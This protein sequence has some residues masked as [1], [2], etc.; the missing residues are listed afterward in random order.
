MNFHNQLFRILTYI[1]VSAGYLCGSLLYGTGVATAALSI[2]NNSKLE[3]NNTGFSDTKSLNETLKGLL[4]IGDLV[5]GKL[6]VE[7]ISQKINSENLPDST[8]A[9]SYY[10]LGIYQLLTRSY[11]EA[12]HYLTLCIS[13]KEKNKK[14]DNLYARALYN[15]SVAFANLGEL[16]E[17]EYYASKSLKVGKTIYGESSPVLLN[18]YLSLISAY[19]DLKEYEKAITNSNIALTIANQNS[20]AISPTVLA[21]LYFNLGVCSYR[22]ADYSKAKIYFDKTESI[23]KNS[24]LDHDESY[25]N[26]LNGFAINYNSLGLTSESAEYYDKGVRLAILKN[27]PL[28]LNLIN[29]YSIFLGNRGHVEKGEKLLRDALTRAKATY[30]QNPHNYFEV[31]NNYSNY[32]LEYM[33][34]TKRSIENYILCLSYLKNN[35]QD[36]LLKTSVCIG[37]SRALEKAGKSE[38]ALEVIHSLLFPERGDAT[39]SGNFANPAFETLKP[40]NTSLKILNLKYNILWDIYRKKADERIL[41]AASNTSELIV[42]LLDKA[43]INISEEDSRLILGDKYRDSYL[44]AIRD[45]NLLYNISH[46]RQYLE[47]AFEYSE[48]SKVAGLLTS[49]RELKAAQFHIPSEIG[50]I[51]RDLQREISLINAHISEES[52]SQKPNMTLISNWKENLLNYSRKRDSLILVIEKK[53]PEYYAIKYNTQMAGL[54]DIPSIVGH[55][56]NYI[57]YVLSDTVLYTFIV[58]RRYQQILAIPVDSSFFN[59]IR[60]FRLLLSMPSPSDDAY[61]KFNE[62]QTIGYTLYKKLIEPIKPYLISDRILISP[63]N[64]LSYLPFETIPSSTLAGGGIRYKDI[65]YLMDSYDISYT[66]SATFAAESVKKEYGRNNKLIAFAPDYPEPI[67]IQSTLMSRQ[68]GMGVLNDLPFA[69]Q[70]AKYV[71]DLTGG[72]LFENS[73]AKESVYKR[74]SG[75]YDIIHLAMH[76]LLNDKDPMHS[77]L[78]FSRGNDSP[79]D[80]FLKTYEVYGIPL[81]AK[82]VFL[83]SCNTGSGLLYSGEGILSLARGFIYSGSQSVVMSMWEIEDKSGTEIVEKFYDN[84]RKGYSKSVSLKRARMTFLKNAD[85]LRSHPYF[86]ATLVVYGNNTPLY[87][88][89]KLIIIPSAILI[90]LGLLAGVYYRKRKYS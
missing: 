20:K 15:L 29:S 76:T 2:N 11:K 3:F 80:G 88:P 9:E 59:C 39:F 63:D 71:S 82:M 33:S 17:F 78:I 4:T 38:K 49:T 77:T 50:D 22:L 54:K 5:N 90:I 84:L 79:Q 25:I 1:I 65:S 85:Q 46:N 43:R 62:F 58:N 51:E 74:E 37:Y 64:I 14:I 26:V 12:I 45:F 66:Y 75:K 56:G 32:L 70:E 61:L 28:A 36:L 89:R 69:R 73:K 24:K 19:T 47:K 52:S 83:S 81:K 60:K 35:N 23:Y 10:Y 8:L 40:D 72:K 87:Y 53:Y 48:K 34:D 57:N 7:K 44:H 86:W 16:N 67:D 6:I 13:V 41:E 42:S 68:G 27:S 30:S 18:S 21:D 55:N 31:L